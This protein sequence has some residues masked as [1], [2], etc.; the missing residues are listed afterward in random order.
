MLNL[1]E[2]ALHE[3]LMNGIAILHELILENEIV[4]SNL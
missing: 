4:Q 1:Q 2:N 3:L